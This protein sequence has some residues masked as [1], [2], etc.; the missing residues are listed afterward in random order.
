MDCIYE[1]IKETRILRGMSQEEL[2]IKS[3]YAGRAAINRIEKGEID[4]PRTK[5]IA[6]A[7]A[8]DVTPAFLLGYE[9]ENA[10]YLDP[11][12]AELAQMLAERPDLRALLDA[13]MDATP[14]DIL[15]V[16]H[17]LHK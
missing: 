11:K 13:S 2:A 16:I 6:I 7:K 15:A 1:R 9:E 3:G 5:L 12:A 14:E 17:L 10:I 8:L 4:L